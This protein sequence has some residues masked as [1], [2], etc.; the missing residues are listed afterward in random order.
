[1]S[2]VNP[3]HKLTYTAYK[4][5]PQAPPL[6][7]PKPVKEDQEKPSSSPEETLLSKSLIQQQ[8][9]NV[10]QDP[11]SPT[12]LAQEKPIPNDFKPID[13]STL[14]APPKRDD[15]PTP[16]TKILFFDQQGKKLSG[17]VQ[18]FDY[19]GRTIVDVNGHRHTITDSD[20]QKALLNTPQTFSL[21]KIPQNQIY[22]PSQEFI[23]HMDTA[24]NQ[25]IVGNQT[26]KDYLDQLY[27]QG[28][29][30]YVVGGAV[31]DLA[32]A[33]ANHPNLSSKQAGSLLNDIDITTMANPNA[34]KKLY[35]QFHKNASG[36]TATYF[37]EYGRAHFKDANQD[38]G[39]D[40]NTTVDG[41]TVYLP[42]ER[43]PDTPGEKVVPATFD[44]DLY[45]DSRSRDFATNSLY[46]DPYNKV[47]VDPT[48]IGM[49]DAI[50]KVL[51]FPGA[52][53]SE[54]TTAQED[55]E[56]P[57]RYFK[58]RLR[59]YTSNYFTT[60][61]MLENASK[62]YQSWVNKGESVKFYHEISRILPKQ[63]LKTEEGINKG[64]DQ[65]NQ[66][67]QQ[68]EKATNTQTNLTQLI[69]TNR[70]QITHYI[71]TR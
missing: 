65:L 54:V 40:Y 63:D 16:G 2:T 20:L 36:V 45:Q 61:L 70:K 29:E 21:T 5:P 51:R 49:S 27:K 57:R 35:D 44:H 32:N 31:R 18:G 53:K 50:N 60:N 37:P 64:L 48:G 14:K 43:S 46:Y 25:K 10:Q 24:L 3:D 62:T 12:Y 68:D 52:S 71:L 28:Y 7:Q 11:L 26:A 19:K 58:F 1:M 4:L 69:D 8:K 34:A 67:I 9:S 59:G 55:P 33:T 13:A 39:F 41:T 38:E 6:P 42:K 56:M 47:I 17:T 66:I 23:D 22:K 15:L 30:T